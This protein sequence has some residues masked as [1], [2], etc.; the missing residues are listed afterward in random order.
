M[1]KSILLF[2]F[3]LSCIF[4]FAT[5]YQD[6][7]AMRLKT[8]MDNK[9]VYVDKKE[10]KIKILKQFLK[11]PHLP[12]NQEYD[13]NTKLYEEY[14]KYILDS[15]IF[16]ISKNAEIAKEL[17]DHNLQNEANIRLATLYS[18]SGMYIESKNILENIQKEQLPQKLLE[19][20]YNAYSEFYGH[21]AQ[22]NDRYTYYHLNEIYRDSLLTVLDHKSMS[23]KIK[24]VQKIFFQG[25]V[26]NAEK[27]LLHLLPKA[28]DENPDRAIIAY[29]LGMVYKQ[30]KD[31]EKERE[32]CMI[33]A[34]TDIINAIKDN[35]SLQTL[36]LSYYDM[37]DINLAY[38]YMKAAIDD[39][40]FCNVRFRTIET[41]S[42][43]TSI[44]A[45]YQSEVQ[46]QKDELTNYLILISILSLFLIAAVFYVYKQMKRVSRIRKELYHTNVKLQ[47]MIDN[48]N[49]TNQQIKDINLQ[50][51][52]SNHIKEE[53]IAYFFDMC[54]SYINKL[55]DYRKGL[56]KKAAN[57]Q[58][59]ELFK[60]LK[61]NTIIEN[62]REELYKKFD[63]IFLSLYPTFID[64][65]NNLLVKEE[66]I[67]LKQGEL[68]NTELRI[69]A[70]IRLG[71]TDSVKIASFLRYSLSTIYNYRTK[72][73]NKA[74]TA[75]DEFEEMVIKIGT[76]NRDK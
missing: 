37:G 49:N 66:R 43:F 2:L 45:S 64:D 27:I 53:Y 76:P 39:A 5:S 13:I 32:Y 74:A 41:S 58:L 20:Y 57:N 3:S 16:Y 73:R 44:N 75:R 28:S 31:T 67:T 72:A 38:K 68:L 42:F 52:E 29:L 35:A 9:Q 70:L 48:L 24:Y 51:S 22:S 30:K 56:N 55:E 59:D 63:T 46:K 14:Q 25:E 17:R 10:E 7:L 33:S 54:S 12:L 36:A 6:S 11:S 61:S 15:A 62:E 50:L 71:I 26:D 47:N 65:F 21:Y 69:F 1:K 60:M 23:Y 4:S 34:I 40:T 18:T 19:E 8:V